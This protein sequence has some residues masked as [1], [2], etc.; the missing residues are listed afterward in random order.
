MKFNKEQIVIDVA[1][2]KF[3]GQIGQYPT[4]LIGT[5]FY[6]KHKIVSDPMKGTF[7][8]SKAEE[9]IKAQE[10]MSDK[11]GNPAVL[12]VVG[13]TSEALIKYIDFA[14]EAAEEPFLVDSTAPE[15][16]I[17]A[18][19]HVSEVGLMRRAIY[20]SIMETP[21]QS[22]IDA[23]RDLDVESSIILA[24]NSRDMTPEGRIKVLKGEGGKTGLLDFAKEAGIQNVIVDTAVLDVPSIAYAARAIQLVREEFGLPAGCG[25]SNAITAW[26]KV[27]KGLMGPHAYVTT[28]S[29]AALYTSLMGGSYVLYG[30]I[31]EAY[32]V[33]PAIAMA[34]AMTAYYAKRTYNVK[35]E[36]G[37]H[38]MYKIFER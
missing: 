22:E 34:D 20:N 16:R 30:P 12:D 17:E 24:F 25:P 7:D 21:R 38:P 33:F 15:V 23:L 35:P 11:T 4:V 1:G 10:E 13:N 32:A 27:K 9:L 2:V 6:D 37:K 3:G 19:R 5:I 8:K 28:I 31:E 36:P 18:M 26:K 29:G 14:A